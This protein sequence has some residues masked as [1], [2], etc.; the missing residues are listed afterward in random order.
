MPLELVFKG[1]T[2]A[3]LPFW[4]LLFVAPRWSWTQRL[5]NGPV[6]VLLLA[7]MYAYLLLGYGTMPEEM[8]F[9][10]LYGLMVGF[11][12]PHLV[13]AGWIHYL[14]FDLFIGAWEVRDAVRREV[15]HWLVV[16]CLVLT[17][18]AGPIGLLAYV[19]VRFFRTGVL[20]FEETDS[21]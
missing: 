15:S 2:Y 11:S 17:L 6:A 3:V 8:N 18:M 1:V 19:I 21:A 20:E 7:P 5:V 16:P 12:V 14:L 4:F 13:M 10:T 9:R